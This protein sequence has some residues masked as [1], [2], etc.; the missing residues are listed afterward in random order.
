[1]QNQKSDPMSKKP[2]IKNSLL[3]IYINMSFGLIII[4]KIH[5]LDIYGRHIGWFLC[6]FT[7][8]FSTFVVLLL[9]NPGIQDIFCF[10]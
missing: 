5:C 10:V 3:E 6:K 7:V 8:T 4:K 1:M 2:V 9:Q